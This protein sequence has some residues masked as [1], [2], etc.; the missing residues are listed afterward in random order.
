M[1][2]RITDYAVNSARW[3][4][5]EDFDGEVWKDVV[6]WED[7]YLVSNFGRVKSK[8]RLGA[9]GIILKQ[10]SDKYGY[11]KVH[12]SC[13]TH[14]KVASV[15]RLVALAFL[16]NPNKYPSINHK[17]E[18]KGN[19][20]VWNL[21]WCTVAYNDGYGT[22]N[23]KCAMAQRNDKGRSKPVVCYNRNKEFVAYYP[24]IAEAQRHTGIHKASISRACRNGGGHS[25]GYLWF[26]ANQTDNVQTNKSISRE[27]QKRKVV[28]LSLNNEFIAEYPSLNEAAKVTGINVGNIGK[29]CKHHHAHSRAGKYRWLYK[30]EYTA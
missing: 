9:K 28:Q 20:C 21:E 16:P 1:A 11:Y 15:H 12:L 17:D 14:K 25:N 13:V 19:N 18:N 26:W 27:E 23:I 4:S 2:D 30:D 5:L 6:S 22:R 7:Y 8:I 29:C 10:Q 3:L 24:S